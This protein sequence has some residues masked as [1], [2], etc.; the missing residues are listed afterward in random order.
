[1]FLG[2][3]LSRLLL[4]AAL[5]KA[6]A[7]QYL[8]HLALVGEVRHRKEPVRCPSRPFGLGCSTHMISHVK[9]NCFRRR[10]AEDSLCEET[11]DEA[12]VT[13]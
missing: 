13:P 9:I 8:V 6:H 2:F 4:F 7:R 11:N 5:A 10:V 1:M 3:P 12:F